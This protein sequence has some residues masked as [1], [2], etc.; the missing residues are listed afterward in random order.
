MPER[1][2]KVVCSMTMCEM[3]C[4]SSVGLSVECSV[5][6]RGLWMTSYAMLA[7]INDSVFMVILSDTT[8]I[9][10]QPQKGFGP[11]AQ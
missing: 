9:R 11:K 6:I 4:S 7:Y 8:K 1:S 10:L 5:G 3:G 2:I